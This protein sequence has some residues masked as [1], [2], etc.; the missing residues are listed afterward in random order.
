MT[1]TI[2]AIIS[3]MR[4]RKVN[5]GR[6]SSPTLIAWA[7]RLEAS[8]S[9]Q[10]WQDISTAPKDGSFVLVFNQLWTGDPVGC[11]WDCDF[12]AWFVV[13]YG[14]ICEPPPTLWL[15]TTPAPQPTAEGA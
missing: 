5:H 14:D 8:A 4:A 6:N 1:D 15:P 13:D 10:G 11:S 7:D 9:Q 2:E 12:G 3:E